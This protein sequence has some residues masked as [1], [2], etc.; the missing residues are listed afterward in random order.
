MHRVIIVFPGD[1]PC[2]DEFESAY[3]RVAH[4]FP[5]L[6]TDRIQG[7]N[8]A[9]PEWRDPALAIVF[10]CQLP[11][12]IPKDRLARC[13]F[14][15]L[16]S[17]GDPKNL[18]PG[19]EGFMRSFL[20]R[21]KQ[22]DLFLVTTPTTAEYWNSRARRV[23]VMPIGFDAETMGLPDWTSPKTHDVGFCGTV[24]GRREWVI[25]ILSKHFGDRFRIIISCGLD[26]RRDFNSCRIMLHVAHSDEFGL[27]TL[28]IWQALSTSAAMATERRDAWPAVSGRH[29]LQIPPARRED[30]S[31]FLA[32]IEEALRMPL[33]DIARVAHEELSGYTVERCIGDFMMPAV[34]SL[35]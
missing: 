27:P 6:S 17:T 22:P 26:M 5:S 19:Q 16:E 18:T 31:E 7:W 33:P 29:I 2:F 12:I 14:Y 13:V 32:G 4:A 34:S 30:P 21:A 1:P 8:P 23:A 24:V 3:R 20:K 10:W 35:F 28:R 9:R 11:A 15:H 25:P